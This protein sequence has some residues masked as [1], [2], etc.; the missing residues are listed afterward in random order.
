MEIT[1]EFLK[2]YQFDNKFRCGDNHDGGYV[3][4]NINEAY[5]CYISAGVSNEE[6][7]SRD[8]INTHNMDETNSFAFDGTIDDYPYNYT[9]KITF[10]KKNINQFN[11]DNN[12]NLFFLLEKYTNVFIKMDIEGFEYPWL[13]SLDDNM[14]NNIKQI[15][16]EFHN[17]TGDWG[18]NLLDKIKCLH[19][20]TKYHYLIHAHGNNYGPSVNGIPDTIELTYINKKCFKSIPDLNSTKLPIDMLDSTNNPLCPEIDLNCYPFVFTKMNN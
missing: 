2:V 14:L 7:F 5:D 9:N 18:C 20:M 10:I 13:L 17:I 15:V 19:K 11:D 1:K 6:S 12:T 4:G 3:I 8:F 16:I